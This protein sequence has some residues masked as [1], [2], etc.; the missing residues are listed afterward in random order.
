MICIESFG[1]LKSIW[2]YSN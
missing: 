1:T 2:N